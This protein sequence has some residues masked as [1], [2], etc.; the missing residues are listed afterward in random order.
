M[1]SYVVIYSVLTS[2]VVLLN[3][4]LTLVLLDKWQRKTVEIKIRVSKIKTMIVYNTITQ[5]K[6]ICK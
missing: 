6:S 5:V 1:S 2:S 3:P 4:A